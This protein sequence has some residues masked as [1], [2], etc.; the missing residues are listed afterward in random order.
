MIRI[1]FT[2]SSSVLY[3][4]ARSSDIRFRSQ[5]SQPDVCGQPGRHA[6]YAW[7]VRRTRRQAEENGRHFRRLTGAA[8]SG[9][10]RVGRPM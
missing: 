10:I 9:S 3:L 1:T 4:S 8:E 2:L 5:V 6:A 7:N